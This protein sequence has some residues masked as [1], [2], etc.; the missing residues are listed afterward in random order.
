MFYLNQIKIL[1]LFQGAFDDVKK[2][3]KAWVV[4]LIIL[5][6]HVILL[7]FLTKT[8]CPK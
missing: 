8:N 3:I 5:S 4:V 7:V 6:V 1:I 2:L